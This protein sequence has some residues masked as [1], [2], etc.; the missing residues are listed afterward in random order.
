M[1]VIDKNG[2]ELELDDEV[3]VPSPDLR[4]GDL[5][6]NE[7]TGTVVG[8]SESDN[9]VTVLDQEDNGFDIEADR[10]VKV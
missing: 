10:V 8:I 2:V 1:G 4:L 7:F 6:N 3:R 9:L 5:H